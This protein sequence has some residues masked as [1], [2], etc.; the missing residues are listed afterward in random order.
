MG[1]NNVFFM[2]ASAITLT[3]FVAF[4]VLPLA[5]VWLPA[6][7]GLLSMPAVFLMALGN[8]QHLLWNSLLQASVSTLAS[9]A[10]GIPAAYLI[11]RRS[12]PGK[13][14]LKAASLVPFVFP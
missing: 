11:A 2:I 10:I 6:I 3:Y 5:L 7:A 4:F 9:A 14:F 13:R 8:S 1:K 12:F